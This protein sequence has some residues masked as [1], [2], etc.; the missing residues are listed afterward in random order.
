MAL[1]AALLCTEQ[2]G[3]ASRFEPREDAE[4]RSDSSEAVQRALCLSSHAR[5]IVTD[6]AEPLAAEWK[7]SESQLGKVLQACESVVR[8]EG[9]SLRTPVAPVPTS[10]PSW[11]PR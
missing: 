1:A 8:G 2:P 10:S 4:A 11:L 6:C 5:A 7:L 9:S 3:A